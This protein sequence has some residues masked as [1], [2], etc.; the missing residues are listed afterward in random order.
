MLNLGSFCLLTQT[1]LSNIFFGNY[2]GKLLC[3]VF[4]AVVSGVMYDFCSYFKRNSYV[5]GYLDFFLN[6]LQ[7]R[8]F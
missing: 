1:A 4:D 2:Y 6:L 5:I 3:D 7:T 8:L